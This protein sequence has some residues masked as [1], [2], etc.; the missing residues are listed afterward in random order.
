MSLTLMC[1]LWASGFLWPRFGSCISRL[2]EVPGLNLSTT[3]FAFIDAVP[4]CFA[5]SEFSILLPL[6]P[7]IL[8][9]SL[10]VML[11]SEVS[12]AGSRLIVGAALSAST[13]PS[14]PFPCAFLDL[15]AKMASTTLCTDSL[16]FGSNFMSACISSRTIPSSF[17]SSA[18][19]LAA[20]GA[21][22]ESLDFA[23]PRD[24]RQRSHLGRRPKVCHS[25]CR[26]KL[27]QKN[28][29]FLSFFRL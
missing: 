28:I 18:F 15:A 25:T 3:G 20:L 10:R 8:P 26:I 7:D 9:S 17:P 23:S 29:H 5:F 19:I 2:N 12:A 21:P 4:E 13:F 24:E 6:L 11:L 22:G 27:H 1:G 16:S 14:P